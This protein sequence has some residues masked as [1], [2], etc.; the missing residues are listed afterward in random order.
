MSHEGQTVPFSNRLIGWVSGRMQT[1]NWDT[2]AVSWSQK[3]IQK[4]TLFPI[5]I[6]S[7]LCFVTFKFD[8]S[9]D[10]VCCIL[11]R[12]YLPVLLL[13]SYLL[14]WD[15]LCSNVWTSAPAGGFAPGSASSGPQ[16]A[17]ERG[18]CRASLNMTS[19]TTPPTLC[20]T[21]ESLQ[22]KGHAGRPR[23][24]TWNE[25]SEQLVHF[26]MRQIWN[27]ITQLTL[28]S[29]SCCLLFSSTAAL[30]SSSFC[31]CSSRRL[32]RSSTVRSYCSRALRSLS[33]ISCSLAAEMNK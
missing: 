12:L 23:H 20:L 24:H 9:C 1:L 8:N 2:A 7:H 26:Q 29:S 4:K 30:R 25:R 10:H 32:Q 13:T 19:I 5:H 6:L 21:Y 27:G 11:N 28:S 16:T 18:R 33:L 22:D 15:S 17:P 3:E 31:R 14:Q